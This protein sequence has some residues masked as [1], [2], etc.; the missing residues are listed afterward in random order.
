[1]KRRPTR[2]D[3]WRAVFIAE[4]KQ[5]ATA[6]PNDLVVVLVDQAA[7]VADAAIKRPRR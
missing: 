7:D 1:M 3:R 2:F 5:L 6:R 4:L